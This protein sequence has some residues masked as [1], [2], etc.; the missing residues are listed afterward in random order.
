[1]AKDTFN[2][3]DIFSSGKRDAKKQ[4]QEAGREEHE[5]DTLFQQESLEDYNLQYIKKEQIE[6]N[7]EN[8]RYHSSQAYI[9]ELSESIYNT[10]LLNPLIVVPIYKPGTPNVNYRYMLISGEQ[11][12]RAICLK[13]EE[14]YK[15]KFPKGIPARVLPANMPKDTLKAILIICNFEVRELTPYEKYQDVCYLI[16][17]YKKKKEEGYV[18]SAFNEVMKRLNLTRQQLYRYVNISKLIPELEEKFKANELSMRDSAKFGTLSEES[19]RKIYELLMK[20]GEVDNEDFEAIKSID[21]THKQA[22]KQLSDKEEQ[23]AAVKQDLA[24][25]ENKMEN[26]T[27]ENEKKALKKRIEEQRERLDT[28]HQEKQSLKEQSLEDVNSVIFTRKKLKKAFSKVQKA[29]QE[30]LEQESF[31]REDSEARSRGKDELFTTLEK[32]MALIK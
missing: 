16:E 19:Q 12:W 11:R 32:V 24:Q 6:V 4:K 14:T 1:M 2:L 29:C 22:E 23:L 25:L 20:K 31:L 13:D 8:T 28:L 9:E 18:S 26:V 3:D 7:P 30:I 27:E 17:Y 10:M 21:L 15:S 5:I